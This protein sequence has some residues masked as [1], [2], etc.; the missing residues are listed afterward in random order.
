M[1]TA[2]INSWSVISVLLDSFELDNFSLVPYI[3]RRHT[4]YRTI[5]RFEH[6][7]GVLLESTGLSVERTRCVILFTNRLPWLSFA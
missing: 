4:V 2:C 1:H 3:L 5:R 6:C 7:E